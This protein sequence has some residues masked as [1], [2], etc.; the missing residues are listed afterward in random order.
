MK[1]FACFAL[2][3]FLL[4]SCAACTAETETPP[5][6]YYLRTEE[7]I[8][9]GEAQG[10]ISPVVRDLPQGMSLDAALQLYLDGPTE[11]NFYTPIPKGTYLLSTISKEDHIV[12]VLSR[13]FSTLD[14]IQ[15]TLAG[16][17]LAATCHE[18]TGIGK[19]HVRS[20]E[21]I[22]DFDLNSF[23]FLD[24]SAGT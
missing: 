7:T 15:L 23:V 18:L 10:F 11:E 21:N 24:D 4:L 13:E 20:G 5:K 19:I 2:I 12:I 3:L 8:L 1:R 6:F 22:Y 16:A 17:C 9:Y 14:G